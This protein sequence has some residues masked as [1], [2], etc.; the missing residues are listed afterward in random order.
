MTNDIARSK[1]PNEPDLELV[2]VSFRGVELYL[3]TEHDRR[4]V[5]VRVG[6][7]QS[8]HKAMFFPHGSSEAGESTGDE[9][10]DE[11]IRRRAGEELAR[12]SAAV[13]AMKAAA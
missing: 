12:L 8:W 7:A 13:T 1:T 4:L 9:D 6:S 2:S 5:T 3:T 10:L 11:R